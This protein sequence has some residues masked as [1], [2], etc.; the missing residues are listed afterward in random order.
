[1]PRAYHSPRREADAAATRAGIV[2]A[3]ARLFIRD[4]YAATSMK[5]IAAEAGVSPQTVQLH[6]PKHAL[7]I[8]AFETAFAGDEGSHSLTDR[9]VMAEIMGEPNFDVALQKYVGFLTRA[10]A[11]SATVVR[12]MMAAAD[13][14]PAVRAAYAELEQRRQRD[15]GLAAQWFVGRERIAAAHASAGADVLSHLTGPDTYLHFT[16]DRGW[17]DDRYSAWVAHQ[18]RTLDQQVAFGENAPR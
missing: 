6:G 1:M 2:A 17:S 13:A 14:D 9:P 8:G 3:A 5:A 12:A 15:M 11:R 10:N 4:G 7:L 18:L 16:Q